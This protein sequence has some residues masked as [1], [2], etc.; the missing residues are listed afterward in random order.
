[1]LA[2]DNFAVMLNANARQMNSG[3]DRSS[4]GDPRDLYVSEN[5]DDALAITKDIT[6][7]IPTVF[8]GG[9]DGTFAR[10]VNDWT[11]VGG[12]PLPQVGVLGLGTGNAVAGMVSSGNY[13]VDLNSIE[14]RAPR[15]RTASIGKRR[16]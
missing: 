2:T 3:R 14:H 1:M 15:Y 10:F 9:G 5:S 16:W 6:R 11:S 4:H 7:A 13:E 8:T 12:S